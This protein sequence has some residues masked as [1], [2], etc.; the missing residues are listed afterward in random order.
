MLSNTKKLTLNQAVE[1]IAFCEENI[2]RINMFFKSW[3]QKVRI[4]S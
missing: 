4:L 1:R 3:N 2:E